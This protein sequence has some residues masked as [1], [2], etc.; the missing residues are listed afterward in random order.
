MRLNSIMKYENHSND[1]IKHVF[2]LVPS[3]NMSSMTINVVIVV[4]LYI[5]ALRRHVLHG[6]LPRVALQTADF[7]EKC[8]TLFDLFNCFGHMPS[9]KKPVNRQ[10]IEEV[11]TVSP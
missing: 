3:S 5:A 6:S 4:L 2:A 8:N 1:D 10:N 11:L 7:L 9:T